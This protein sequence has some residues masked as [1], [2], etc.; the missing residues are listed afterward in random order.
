MNNFD[1][2]PTNS[3]V[4]GESELLEDE[5]EVSVSEK[6][7]LFDLPAL[8]ETELLD[9]TFLTRLLQVI[10]EKFGAFQKTN[11]DVLLNEITTFS[12]LF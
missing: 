9:W 2:G 11:W 7:G 6:S 12:V 4:I 5:L 8:K 3:W 1:Y 10:Q